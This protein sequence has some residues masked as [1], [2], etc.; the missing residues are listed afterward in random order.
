MHKHDLQNK[1]KNRW[2]KRQKESWESIKFINH[3]SS[4]DSHYIP[5]LF[6]HI[7]LV[8]VDGFVRLNIGVPSSSAPPNDEQK[9]PS[10]TPSLIFF[11]VQ[12]SIIR[13]IYN[14]HYLLMIRHSQ[15][16]QYLLSIYIYIMYIHSLCVWC[17]HNPRIVR[18]IHSYIIT[19]KKNC[20][21]YQWNLIYR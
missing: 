14:D 2:K 11:L 20:L 1:T 21:L 6:S 15:I 16:T 8:R 7:S 12:P 18:L 17:L 19:K 13:H 4:C 10:P 3:F 9:P 5:Q